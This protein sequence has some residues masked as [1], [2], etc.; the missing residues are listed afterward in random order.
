MPRHLLKEVKNTDTVIEM[1]EPMLRTSAC[2]SE[3][4]PHRQVTVGAQ[5][6]QPPIHCELDFSVH[7]ENSIRKGVV[8]RSP[9][10]L[11]LIRKHGCLRFSL[12]PG[13][14]F[15]AC[16]RL[17]LLLHGLIDNID[18]IVYYFRPPFPI[19]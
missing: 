5:S 1:L 11:D 17:S 18:A 14:A 6:S 10:Y 8:G 9:A 16:Q 2:E 15:L 13:I 19:F 4:H 12:S 7:D 3:Q